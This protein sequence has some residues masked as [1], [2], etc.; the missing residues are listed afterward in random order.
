[1]QPVLSKPPHLDERT[2][3]RAA[4]LLLSGIFTLCLLLNA[5]TQQ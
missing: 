2:A 5:L 1:M 4:A 3:A